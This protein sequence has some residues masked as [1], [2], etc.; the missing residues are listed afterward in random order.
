MQCLINANLFG[1]CLGNARRFKI[2]NGAGFQNEFTNDQLNCL[3]HTKII[4][5][6]IKLL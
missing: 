1:T 5:V 6:H 4:A 3:Q 2:K